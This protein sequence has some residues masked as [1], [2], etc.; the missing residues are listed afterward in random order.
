MPAAEF[1][2]QWRKDGNVFI[3]IKQDGG[4][5]RTGT[6]HSLEMQHQVQAEPEIHFL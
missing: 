3:K 2:H 5:S 4:Q 1:Y 6:S